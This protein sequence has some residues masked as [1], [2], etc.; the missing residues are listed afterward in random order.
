MV[1]EESSKYKRA[2]G[3]KRPKNKVEKVKIPERQFLTAYTCILLPMIKI[4]GLGMT[5]TI[6]QA[7][8]CIQRACWEMHL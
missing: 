3:K 1:V 8:P 2:N 4:S 6:L 5:N 7:Q